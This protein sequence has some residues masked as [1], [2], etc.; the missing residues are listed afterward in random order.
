MKTEV[1]AQSTKGQNRKPSRSYL[2]KGNNLRSVLERIART[3]AAIVEILKQACLNPNST[4][5][6]TG[7]Q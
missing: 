7:A 6:P 4:L 1:N 5:P 3:N 2:R